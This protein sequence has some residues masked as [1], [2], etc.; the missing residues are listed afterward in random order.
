[1]SRRGLHSREEVSAG[2]RAALLPMLTAC[3]A[4][5]L[6][7]S[8]L[9]Q[10]PIYDSLREST[11]RL[12]EQVEALQRKPGDSYGPQG[13]QKHMSAGGRGGVVVVDPKAGR[14][15]QSEYVSGM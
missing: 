7:P 13:H 12:Q 1:M 3:F 10:P 11:L 8:L 9:R 5:L 6:L 14:Q 4:A 15:D 2:P